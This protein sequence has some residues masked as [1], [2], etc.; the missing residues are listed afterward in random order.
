MSDAGKQYLID[1]LYFTKK[2]SSGSGEISSDDNV[3]DLT[4]IPSNV[5]WDIDDI[6]T[7]AEPDDYSVLQGEYSDLLNNSIK[8]ITQGNA[9]GE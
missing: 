8:V 4:K 1:P 6:L 7:G 3:Y 2:P 9:S 5:F